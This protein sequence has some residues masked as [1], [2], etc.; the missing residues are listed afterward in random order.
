MSESSGYIYVLTNKSMPG[1]VKI[2]KTID[3]PKRIQHLSSK[4]SVPLPF[5]LYKAI[6]VDNRHIVE[7]QFKDYF[8]KYRT[9]PSREFFTISP[10]ETDPLFEHYAKIGAKIFDKSKLVEN[11]TIKIIDEK[12]KEFRKEYLEKRKI[13]AI[14]TNFR[15]IRYN[16]SGWKSLVKRGMDIFQNNTNP[17]LKEDF[18]RA[19]LKKK[20]KK[21]VDHNF[22]SHSKIAGIIDITAANYSLTNNGLEFKRNDSEENFKSCLKSKILENSVLE[23]YPY[24]VSMKILN[25]VKKLSNIEFLWGIYIMQDTSVSEIQKC[26]ERIENI[27]KINIDYEKFN[28]LKDLFYIMSVTNDL[29]FKFKHQIEISQNN[30]NK[31]KFEIVDFVGLTLS[32]LDL[33]FKYFKNHMTLIW[34]NEYTESKIGE[35]KLATI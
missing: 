24:I 18:K 30:D 33:E 17:I 22:A 13:Y 31:K 12:V 7:N 9:N 32:R 27:K 19:Y 5:K 34:P 25:K 8:D 15:I 4:T 28:N 3:V 29:N 10:E 16:I 26:I 14:N 11:K 35:L 23:F 20:G 1:L 2:G 6:K 21:E